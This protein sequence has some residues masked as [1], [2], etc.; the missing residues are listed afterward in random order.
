MPTRRAGKKWELMAKLQL[1]ALGRTAGFTTSE[2]AEVLGVSARTARRY[3][4]ELSGMDDG[5]LPVS[6]EKGIWQLVDGA[7]PLRYPVHLSIMEAMSVY[8]AVRLMSAHSTRYNPYSVDALKQLARIMPPGIAEHIQRTAADIETRRRSTDFVQILTCLAEAWIH[9]RQVR[10]V[11]QPLGTA[12]TPLGLDPPPEPP[13]S[14]QSAVPGPTAAPNLPSDSAESEVSELSEAGPE[15]SGPP[16]PRTV[17][18]YFLEPTASSLG[19]YLIAHDHSRD[20]IRVFK[21]ERILSAE[22]L[23]TKFEVRDDFDPYRHLATAWGIIGGREPTEVRLRF[24]AGVRRRVRESDWP[25]ADEAVD[26]SDGGCELTVQVSNPLEMLPWIRS[27]GPACEVLSPA[28]LRKQVAG[29]MRAA[30]ARY[31]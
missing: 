10:M 16:P 27:W 21:V 13:E 3:I 7:S 9:R 15:P 29:D 17:D 12:D 4:S 30:A 14:D 24:A 11:Y 6:Y 31:G 19:C 20:A 2:V 23:K 5:R 8:L 18:P 28:Q 25:G 26:T 1:F 22:L